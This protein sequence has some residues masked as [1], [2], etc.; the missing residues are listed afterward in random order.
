MT[1]ESNANLVKS[2]IKEIVGA[3]D[4]TYEKLGDDIVRQQ[5]FSDLGLKPAPDALIRPDDRDPLENAR[6][7][8]GPV[9]PDLEAFESA[10]LDI[11]NVLNALDI[12]FRSAE[13]PEEL[14]NAA[15]NKF[16]T[17]MT[18]SHV[19]H[20][21]PK[22]YWW[23][24]L[25][26]FVQESFAPDFSERILGLDEVWDNL[27]NRGF[28]SE[29]SFVALAALLLYLKKGKIFFGWDPSPDSI[30]PTA[31]RISERSLSA[32]FSIPIE[33]TTVTNVRS[34]LS[35]IDFPKNK[36][37]LIEYAEQ[38]K[39]K[40]SDP[41]P[42][43]EILKKL[44]DS[45][46][47]NME[48]VE[49]GLGKTSASINFTLIPIPADEGGPALFIS[50]GGS[51]PNFKQV[52]EGD[53][54]LEV[55]LAS[56]DLIQMLLPLPFGD[57]TFQTLKPKIA[58][59]PISSSHSDLNFSLKRHLDKPLII[60]PYG[61]HLELRDIEIIGLIS[62]PPE[63]NDD[64]RYGTKIIAHNSSLVIDKK[65]L[66]NFIAKKVPSNQIHVNFN[67]GFGWDNLHGW[68]FEG[69]N[70]LSA[71]IPINEKIGPM[72]IKDISLNVKPKNQDSPTFSIELTTSLD[73]TIGPVLISVQ[74][75]GVQYVHNSPETTHRAI[76]IPKF[77]PK[78]PEGIGLIIDSHGVNGG[79]FI[80]KS[81]NRYAGVV[82][83]QLN[84]FKRFG[85][86][87]A[88]A[89]LDIDKQSDDMSL[90]LALFLDLK[91]PVEL[92]AGFKISKIGGFIGF[93]RRISYND[94]ASGMQSGILDSIMFPDNPVTNA[95][96]IIGDF[97]RVF[98]VQSGH[99]VIGPAIRIA[100]GLDNLIKGDLA[101]LLAFEPFELSIL[102]K[103]TCR[104]P[105]KEP[106]I[107]IN[108]GILG[109]IDFSG[110]TA[111]LYGSLYYSKILNYP[112]TG[113][114]AMSVI[115]SS[116]KNFIFSVGGFNPK[117]KAPSN[118]P[119]F[120]A[121]P[122]KRLNLAF[123]SYVTF[124]CYLALTSNTFQIGA[125]VEAKFEKSGAKISGFLGF[126]ALIQFNPLYY[127]IDVAGGFSV[128]FKGRSLT[129]ITFSGFIEGPNPQR[130]KGSLTFSIL[131]WDISIH[132]DKTFGDQLP[133][134]I[135]LVELWP[136]LSDALLQEDSWT[137]E[138][139]T[140]ADLGVVIKEYPAIQGGDVGGNGSG[141]GQQMVHPLGILKVSQKVVPLNFTLT[142]FGASN[143]K[144]YF[145][146]EIS[147]A[148]GSSLSSVKDYFAPA[149]FTE[150]DNSQKLTLKS[151]ELMDSG[152]SFVSPEQELLFSD[153]SLSHK[154]ISYETKIFEDMANMNKKPVTPP[155][156][157]PFKLDAKLTEALILAGAA[158]HSSVSNS[159]KLKY[160]PMNHAK[161]VTLR[162]E[163]FIIV[164]Q[165]NENIEMALKP[166]N[167]M[168][169]AAA[170]NK[171]MVDKK[172][173][174][175]DKRNLKVLSRFELGGE[176][177]AT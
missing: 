165:D 89:I 129:S 59:L 118:F 156:K 136:I 105:E 160:E 140:W 134:L 16:L 124:E 11:L 157:E 119:P 106:I 80:L 24:R 73:V 100:Y 97:N 7:F 149:Q 56:N 153:K 172:R 14:V 133:E 49:K 66:D 52:L 116:E 63:G 78:Y 15:V 33:G 121:P 88:V 26:G 176:L 147:S 177:I 79:G 71:A 19:K 76:A 151:Y 125:R 35:G 22:L 68:F 34:I 55:N 8:T 43:L 51:T 42:V 31:D 167:Q 84:D 5:V 174:P 170:I 163:K 1:E 67:L 141:S 53:W 46:F 96:R 104:I 115:W 50:A 152:V 120:G 99:H 101:I 150:Y 158:Y 127:V 102:G 60:G 162:E 29:H 48:D 142:K 64:I 168:S 114:M 57:T 103:V 145:R 25:F 122:L 20:Y 128:S 44:P 146:F 130:I 10:F 117:F 30:T 74:N 159:N 112:L 123:S 144:D 17:V 175:Q 23:A 61:L 6:K 47:G 139:P 4:Y 137:A 171:L 110:E 108:I 98:P 87:Q 126:D 12:Y 107:Q 83:L 41:E 91:R 113:D 3:L 36:N 39:D 65:I 135:T 82:Q 161:E 75:I 132:I 138:T 90:F 45:D 93:N 95:M 2:I 18:L 69:G 166:E 32:S 27:K 169:Q 38:N 54:I 154:E 131:W 72:K 164:D 155:G 77:N 28:F 9:D 70:N 13:N 143:P 86:L 173:N 92:G 40:I 94:I 109:L 85:G 148:T 81:E 111:Q 37:K 21:N 58:G 62:V